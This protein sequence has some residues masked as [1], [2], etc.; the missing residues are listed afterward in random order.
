[1]DLDLVEGPT[2][3]REY[4]E[5]LVQGGSGGLSGDNEREGKAAPGPLEIDGEHAGIAAGGGVH[6]SDIHRPRRISGGKLHKRPGFRSM[7]KPNVCERRCGRRI[8]ARLDRRCGLESFR[9]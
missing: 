7:P 1:M 5:N 6:I 4:P 3:F 8:V 9:A 2:E